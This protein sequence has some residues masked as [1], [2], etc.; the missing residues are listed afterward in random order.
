MH[1]YTRP[2]E[3]EP[4]L[5]Q[6]RLPEL[7]ELAGELLRRSSALGG[8]VNR[9]TRNSIR[10]LLRQMNSY[11]SNLIEGHQT[12]PLDIEKALRS[13]FSGKPKERALQRESAAHMSTQVKI[14]QRLEMEPELRIASAEFLCWIH[15]D[16]Y[17]AM[18][19]EFRVVRGSESNGQRIVL[20]GKLRDAD[21]AVGEHVPPEHSMVPSFLNRFA[22]IYDPGRLGELE[23]I[24]ACAA[25]HHRLAWI[26][27]FLD[28]NGRVTRLFTH[29]W[30]I[31]CRIAGH[32]MWMASRGLARY[33]EEYYARLRAADSPRR[34]DLDGRGNLSDLGLSEFCEFF[35]RTAI[36]QVRFMADLLD[37]DSL[38]R[39]I[40]DYVERRAAAGEIE[41]EA[42]YLL[43]E[44]L[45][46]GEVSRGEASRITGLGER[47]ARKL[48]AHLEAERLI[49]S[50][51]PK[52]P[53]RIGFPARAVPYYFPRLYPASEEIGM[54][55]GLSSDLSAR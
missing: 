21:V 47:T 42:G 52:G 2:S 12:H 25:S 28:G 6:S 23:R 55:G 24:I 39:R 4:L 50:Q 13:D 8:S 29:A 18:P 30:L 35:L 32:G 9:V 54:T 10:E 53:I 31:R 33:R 26:H 1:R 36:D 51:T 14:E 20:P 16:F 11:Y 45:L 7:S 43:R 22:E 5:P 44:T 34:G 37:L 46:R 3:M 41:I 48:M 15:A 38:M 40:A 27:P 19:D 17:Q 49:W